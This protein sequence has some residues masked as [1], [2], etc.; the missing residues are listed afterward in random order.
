M[1]KWKNK[2]F[3]KIQKYSS[4]KIVNFQRFFDEFKIYL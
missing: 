3:S 2:I 4:I 1:F